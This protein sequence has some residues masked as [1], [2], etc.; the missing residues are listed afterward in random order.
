MA[1]KRATSKATTSIDNAAK[2][3]LLAEKKGKAPLANDIPQEAFND[4]TVNSKR[5]RQDN[6]PTLEGTVRTCSSEGVPQAPMP[7]FTPPEAED[8]IEDGEILGILAE[9][10]LKLPALCI[11]NNHLQKQK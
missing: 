5:Q 6:P 11:K 2:V 8:I 9:D 10:Q 3:A 7:G 1:P 4:E